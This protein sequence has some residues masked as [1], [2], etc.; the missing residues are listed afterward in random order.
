MNRP[1]ITV[2]GATGGLGEYLCRYLVQT[3]WTVIP[4]VRNADR[5]APAL[6]PHARVFSLD[7][8]E[9][10]RAALADAKLVISCLK[11]HLGAHMIRAL[12]A[13]VERVVIAGSTRIYT[14]Y[15]DPIVEMLK[16]AEEAFRQS[17]LSGVILHPAMIYGGETDNS[18][19][20]IEAYIRQVG[21]VPLPDGG[22]TLIQ[23]IHIE[24]MV[25]CIMA[26][27]TEMSGNNAPIITAGPVPVSYHDLI[28]A[29]GK[30]IG[31]RPAILSVP[32]AM[33]RLGSVLTPLVPGLP[34]IRSDEV[35]RLGE[36]K[37]FDIS[38]MRQLLKVDP[39]PVEI[40]LSRMFSR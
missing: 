14:R 11:A 23:P 7:D 9:S 30:V 3:G 25:A 40:G 32:Q 24:D 28:L 1:P 12:P 38:D 33:L 34:T 21:I 18:F 15:P 20:R 19:R 27:L 22:R 8:P 4:V 26:A 39:I 17:G 31:K 37:V 2:V 36:D 6:R 29:I 5:L 10:L 13:T 35:R 16:Q